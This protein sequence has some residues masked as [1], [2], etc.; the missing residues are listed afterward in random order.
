MHLFNASL[1]DIS[2]MHLFLASLY[3]IFSMH[4][5]NV[6]LLYLLTIFLKN[7]SRYSSYASAS[8]IA[9]RTGRIQIGATDRASIPI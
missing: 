7:I 3:D 8:R 1:Y 6:S 2:S 4:L 5:F 9:R